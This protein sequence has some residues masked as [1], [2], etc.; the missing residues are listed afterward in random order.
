M[1]T[2]AGLLG[3]ATLFVLHHSYSCA[4]NNSSVLKKVSKAQNPYNSFCFQT[5]KCIGNP[6][7]SI[8]NQNMDQN[9]SNMLLLVKKKGYETVSAFFF[10]NANIYWIN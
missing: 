5:S 4:Q 2:A 3:K 1:N 9:V 7:H 10:T 8:P 6:A